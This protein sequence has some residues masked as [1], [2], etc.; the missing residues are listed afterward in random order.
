MNMLA[1]LEVHGGVLR[2]QCRYQTPHPQRCATTALRAKADAM[3]LWD[4]D[5]NPQ[6]GTSTTSIDSINYLERVGGVWMASKRRW[7]CV[8]RGN[9]QFQHQIQRILEH[10][11]LACNKIN[12]RRP[13][14]IAT[15]RQCSSVV[16][17]SALGARCAVVRCM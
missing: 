1:Q 17:V 9:R 13:T 7:G 2:G 12:K 11:A 8:A 3:A 16:R 6:A 5:P 10:S 4:D 14:S 15:S